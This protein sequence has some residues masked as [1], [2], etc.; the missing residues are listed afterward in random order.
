[1]AAEMRAKVPDPKE[2]RVLAQKHLGMVVATMFYEPSTRTRLSFESAAGRLG[3]HVISTE[4]AGEFSSAIK[5]ESLEDSTK[6]VGRL[7]D[8]MVMRHKMTGASEIAAGVNAIPVISGGDGKGEHPTQALLDLD[9]IQTEKGR[10][11]D[12][13]VVIGGDLANGRTARS[14]ALMLSQHNNN[15]I[16][17][18]ST[19]DFQIGSDIKEHLNLSGT[20]FSETDD[21]YSA[22]EG[23]DAVYWTRLQ[24]ERLIATTADTED[25]PILP[26]A[27]E[28][29]EQA[30]ELLW[31]HM[32]KLTEPIQPKAVEL[33][34]S[35]F[36]IGQAALQV[37]EPDTIIMHPLPRVDE[38][39]PSVDL[40]PRAKYFDQVENGL[41]VRMALVDQILNDA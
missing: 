34:P 23:A 3:A 27:Y 38:I 31:P 1:M 12:L 16:R 41:Y 4:N 2:R 9:T 21:M 37:M 33:T 36:S 20:K 11:S 28:T 32:L 14:L 22:F 6:T 17:F 25:I 7:A 35:A 10:L 26:P 30:V 39:D 24:R 19:P 5:G 8:V 29:V 13:T 40:D 15:Q 18:V